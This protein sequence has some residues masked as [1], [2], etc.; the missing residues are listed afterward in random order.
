MEKL[1]MNKFLKKIFGRI[2]IQAKIEENQYW[3]NKLTIPND[4]KFRNR[5][6]E[7][8]DSQRKKN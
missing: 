1:K 3:I 8:N 5:Q 2:I 7:L 4:I 6:R